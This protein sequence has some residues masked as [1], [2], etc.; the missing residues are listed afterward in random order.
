M[1][2]QLGLKAL[3][4]FDTRGTQRQALVPCVV[5]CSLFVC[6]ESPGSARAQSSWKRGKPHHESG[7]GLRR[8]LAA[9]QGGQSA[10]ANPIPSGAA[11]MKERVSQRWAGASRAE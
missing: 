10:S 4:D 8:F 1:C 9:V 5:G 3:A 7:W 11:S 2:D 6:A